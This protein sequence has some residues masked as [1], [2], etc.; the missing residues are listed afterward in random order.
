MTTTRVRVYI[1][2]SRYG[3]L[4]DGRAQLAVKEWLN[5]AKREV[6]VLGLEQIQAR[7][8]RVLKH[9]TGRYQSSLGIETLGDMN[10]MITDH[11][12]VYGPWLEGTSRRNESTR[13]K[14]YHTFRYVFQRLRKQ[15]AEV[16]QKSLEKY[17]GRMN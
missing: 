16:A 4:F 1:D 5:D 3:P 8:D 14:G 10:Q 6:A 13:F 12:I 7:L 17:L 11:G 2:T 9:P 15:A